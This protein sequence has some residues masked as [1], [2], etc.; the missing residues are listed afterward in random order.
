MSNEVVTYV[1]GGANEALAEV[2]QVA[3][4]CAKSPAV[5]K[6]GAIKETYDVSVL[7]D[8]RIPAGALAVKIRVTVVDGKKQ[9]SQL[10]IAIYQVKGNTL[11]GVYTFVGKGTTFADV[12]RVG[13]HAAQQ[14]AANLGGGSEEERRQGL[15]R[16]I[17][18]RRAG[19]PPW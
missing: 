3:S 11:S 9:S 13:F 8:P 15:H 12:E 18:A 4:Q 5:L 1:P 14:S 16:L 10:G 19:V 2:T 17:A 7:K 6:Q